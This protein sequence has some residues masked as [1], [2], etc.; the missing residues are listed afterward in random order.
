MRA[1]IHAEYY[2]TMPVKTDRVVLN[3]GNVSKPAACV[4]QTEATWGLVRVAQRDLNIDGIFPHDTVNAGQG[5]SAY[6]IDT[7]VYLQHVE[8]EG[9]AIAGASFIAGEPADNDLNGHGTHVAGTVAGVNFGIA[10]KAT[11][12]GVKVLS[13]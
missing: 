2:T 11:I 8:F 10:K 13:Q 3:P 7:G 12:V 6:I 1:L 9:R 4:E 5:V